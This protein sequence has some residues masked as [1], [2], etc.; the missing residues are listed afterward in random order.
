MYFMGY[1]QIPNIW[2]K[3]GQGGFS[4]QVNR[5][6]GVLEPLRISIAFSGVLC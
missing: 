2:V 4:S 5:E 1:A 3:V 6:G